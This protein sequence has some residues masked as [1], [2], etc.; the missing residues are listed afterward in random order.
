MC[1]E[2]RTSS[3]CIFGNGCDAWGY[4]SLRKDGG[5]VP[6]IKCI[7]GEKKTCYEGPS[8][9]QGIGTCRAGVRTCASGR[10]GP[11][12]GQILPQ[13]ETCDTKDNNC[14]GL[15]D[16]NIDNCCENG[17][18][19]ACGED[20]GECQKGTQT[21]AGGTW[22]QCTGGVEKKKELCNDKD[23]DCDG[24]IDED[25]PGKNDA[26]SKEQNGCK[27]SG[28]FHCLKDGSKLFCDAQFSCADR[29]CDGLAC[30]ANGKLCQGGRCTCPNNSGVEVNCTDGK[31]NDCDGKK[32]CEDE[33][34]RNQPCNDGELCTKDDVCTGGVCKGQTFTC[35]SDACTQRKCDG[36][37]CIEIVQKNKA[38]DDNNDCTYDDVCDDTGAC[39]GKT[40]TCKP[41]EAC[42]K[43]KCNGTN[44]CA[45]EFKTS[46]CDDQDD[47][48]HTDVCS[49]GICKG[50][51]I[52]C[53]DDTCGTRKCNGTATCTV[54]PRNEG[55]SCVNNP[56]DTSVC[57]SG[58]CVGTGSVADGT[59]CGTG[60]GCCGG[61][62][63]DYTSD[64]ANCGGCGIKCSSGNNCHKHTFGTVVTGLCD[65]LA[66]ATC[67][68]NG[69][70]Y[71]CWKSTLGRVYRCHCHENSD[72]GPGQT[73]I[74]Q[75]GY[76]N[77]CK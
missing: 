30:D 71:T 47:C 42:I 8:G 58:A 45:P 74:D 68:A 41:E 64:K 54:T 66:T 48:T 29:N 9:T 49:N 14:N 75:T 50:T 26:C 35:K 25:F 18:T 56:C 55:Q 53:K 37:A 70:G 51:K 59:S 20:T 57:R 31:D 73:C 39:K 12:L 52:E 10:F 62:C 28:I 16:E 33:D 63:V 19:R 65:C 46:T 1:R 77:Y 23:D 2:C 17:K 3:D 67:K 13:A 36:S 40:V 32:D 38:C 15:K 72:C 5:G 11:C 44:T 6:D 76:H 22:G 21:C 4:C 43:Y 27:V 24:Q 61:K 60:M 69:Q 7:D 34:C